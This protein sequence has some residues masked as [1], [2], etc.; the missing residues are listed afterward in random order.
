MPGEAYQGHPFDDS[1]LPFQIVLFRLQYVIIRSS[2]PDRGKSGRKV[3]TSVDSRNECESPIVGE[4][5]CE[6]VMVYAAR[7]E[8]DR[9]EPVVTVSYGRAS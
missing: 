7:L 5:D 9:R 2:Q 8:S 3:A 4:A 6:E 1:V